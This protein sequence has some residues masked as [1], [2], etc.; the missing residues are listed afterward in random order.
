ME[1]DK[2]DALTAASTIINQNNQKNNYQGAAGLLADPDKEKKIRK[3][4]D[5]LSKI[6]KLKAQ[7]AEGKTLEKNQLESLN[8]EQDLLDELKSLSI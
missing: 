1:K 6:Q 5:K 2:D 7:L 3:L 8:R 4:N